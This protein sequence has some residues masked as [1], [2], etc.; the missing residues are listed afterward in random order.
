[1][2]TYKLGYVAATKTA[3][4]TLSPDALPG[5]A[6][7]LGTFDHDTD[8]V[9]ALYHHIRDV[10]YKRSSEDPSN[11][12]GFPFNITGMGDISIVYYGDAIVAKFLTA[13]AI[14]VVE[15]ATDT[16]AIK[17]QPADADATNADFTFVSADEG[18]ATVDAAG[19]VTGVAAGTTKITATHTNGGMSVV[20]DIT[21]NAP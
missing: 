11:A 13:A 6:V 19:V 16:I 8:D 10:L 21:V 7:D 4:V 20:V 2:P 12:A 15:A 1:M 17:Y 9:D 5:G 18:V 3:S 14:T